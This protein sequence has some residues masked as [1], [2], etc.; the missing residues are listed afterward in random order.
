MFSPRRTPLLLVLL[1]PVFIL[2]SCKQSDSV[3]TEDAAASDGS[4]G[5]KWALL[6]GIDEYQSVNDL[7]GCA[8]DV[9]LMRALLTGKFDFP[10]DNVKT[11]LN[12]EATR[13]AASSEM[14]VCP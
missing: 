12:S 7:G 2:S 3:P 14:R 4:G 10:S 1:V 13:A 5:R 11:L 9:A 6:V 8:N